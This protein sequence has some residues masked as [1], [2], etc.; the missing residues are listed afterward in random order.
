MTKKQ[1]RTFILVLLIA[2][3]AI[4]G[5]FWYL[6]TTKP[7][8]DF[9][10]ENT[11]VSDIAF[12]SLYPGTYF[13]SDID[14]EAPAEKVPVRMM[15]YSKKQMSESDIL[16]V[17]FDL[18]VSGEPVNESGWIF[19]REEPYAFSSQPGGRVITYDDE[20]IIPG[21]SPEY[22]DSHLPSDDEAKKIAEE[23][24]S[25]HHIEPEGLKFVGTNHNI[26]YNSNKDQWTKSSESINVIYRHYI[27]GSEIFNEK[28]GLEVTINKTV[29]S[30]FLKWTSYQPYRE[31]TI[32]TPEQA[33]DGLQKTGLAVP[34]GIQSPE[35]ATVRTITLGYL[36]ETHSQD[37]DYLIPVYK[38]EGTVYGNGTSAEFFQYIPASPIAANELI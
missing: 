29:S 37:L 17:A 25:V 18:G 10:S 6:A 12:H 22:I 38:I 16:Q 11:S 27:N 14:N 4:L 5:A 8:N 28:L 7:A 3:G 2:I 20:T 23:F 36:G 33:V 9:Q 31:Y 19:I 15:I 24:L 35:N 30:M 21:I 32:I 34:K 1:T 13:V 26:G